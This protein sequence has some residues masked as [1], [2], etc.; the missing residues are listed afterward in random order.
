VE[1]ERYKMG[2]CCKKEAEDKRV[3]SPGVTA[4]FFV[5]INWAT[6]LFLIN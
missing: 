1:E 6:L 4:S 3:K 2:V 5:I